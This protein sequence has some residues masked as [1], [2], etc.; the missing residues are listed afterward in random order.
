MDLLTLAAG[1]L[2]GL[3][4]LGGAIFQ[5]WLG[6]KEAKQNHEMEMAKL[7]LASRIDVQKADLN[8]RSIIEEKSGEAMKA[9]IEAQ[10]SLKPASGW[11]RTFLALFRPGVTLLLW[12]SSMVMAV[13]M[14]DS[15]P[16]LMNFIVSSTFSLF[17][18][19]MGYW[20]GDRSNFKRLEITQAVPRK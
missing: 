14:K 17:T 6:M 20:F 3:L 12:F 18:V 15:N 1:P 19:S 5:K 4:G 11:A 13:W 16:E 9:A 10:A 8:L 7:E 2:G